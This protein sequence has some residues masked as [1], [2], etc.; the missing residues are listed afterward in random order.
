MFGNLW[1]KVND[2]A[3]FRIEAT[4]ID[5][6][7]DPSE[8][9]IGEGSYTFRIESA[10]F[11]VDE[12]LINNVSARCAEILFSTFG[13]NIVKKLGGNRAQIIFHPFEES[14]T[15]QLYDLLLI[16]L[17]IKSREEGEIVWDEALFQGPFDSSGETFRVAVAQPGTSQF[18]DFV[19]QQSPV[20]VR[21]YL[22]EI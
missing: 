18:I 15:V 7:L 17:Y 21:D 20:T 5:A 3:S 6:K 13:Q 22:K 16:D 10:G 19:G 12:T 1:I 2:K 11:Y 4:I 8:D 14:T 9:L